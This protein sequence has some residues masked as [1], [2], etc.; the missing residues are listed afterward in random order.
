MTVPLA[1]ALAAALGTGP[2]GAGDR[3]VYRID[4]AV[5]GA[6][7]AASSLAIALPWLLEDRII[8][9]RCPCDR[10]EVPRW[11]RFAIGLESPA[12]D[13][14]SNA[15]VALSALLPPAVGLLHLGWSRAW[16]EDLVVFAE[17]LAVNG[18]LVTA[19]K[20][21]VQ[22]PIPLAYAGD[23][24]WVREPGSYRAFYS[25]H[26]S[27]AVAALTAAAWTARLRRGEE[28]WPWLAV[29]AVGVSVAVERVA[30]GHHFPSDV[31]VGAAA[32]FAVGTAVPLLHAR[33]R[34]GRPVAIAPWGRGVALVGRF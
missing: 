25:G 15:T 6:I 29:A 31:V 4:P 11:E 34:V 19:V 18:A 28:V 10:S 23:P 7:L 3:S 21:A 16:V 9:L 17:A 5:D 30:G 20:Y 33:R 1:L 2:P 22:R 24:A 27:T 13:F 32:G 8:D 26:V 14:A 12:A